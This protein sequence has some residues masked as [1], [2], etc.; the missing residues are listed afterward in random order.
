MIIVITKTMTMTTA[1][2]KRKQ[3]NPQV[4]VIR[5][6]SDHGESEDHQSAQNGRGVEYYPVP[7]RTETSTCIHAENSNS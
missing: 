1:A 7:S 3:Q 6:H 5:S 4:A 2:G